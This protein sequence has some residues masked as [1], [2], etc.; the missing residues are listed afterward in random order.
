MIKEAY[1][2][3]ANEAQRTIKIK[4]QSTE[5][6][7]NI[8]GRGALT[9]GL[10]GALSKHDSKL[11]QL[12]K[13]GKGALIGGATFGLGNEAIRYLGKKYLEGKKID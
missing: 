10:I 4:G 12:G 6:K 13:A 1:E 5:Q 3:G 11:Q 7:G 9:G 8:I 2:A